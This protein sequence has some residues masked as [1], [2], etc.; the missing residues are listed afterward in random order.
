MKA[1]VVGTGAGGAT[2]AQEL[3]NQGFEVKMVEAGKPFKPLTHKISLLSFLRGSWLIRD[4]S[5]IKRVFPYYKTARSGEDLVI[6]RGV[7]EGGSTTVACGSMVRAETGLKKIG[8]DLTPEYEELEKRLNIRPVPREKWR[9]LSRWMFD[10]AKE[11]GYDPQ[12]TPKAWKNGKCV[13]CGY[14]ELGCRVGAKWDSREFYKDLLDKH[15]SLRTSARV[16]KVILENDR[17]VGVIISNGYSTERIYADIIVLSAGGI[18][19][20]QILKATNLPVRDKLWVDVVLTI[21]GTLKNSNMLQEPPMVWFAKKEHY[22]LSPYFDLLSYWFHNPWKDVS[23]KDLVGMMIKLADVEQ[24]SVDADGTVAKSLTEVD[25][26]H[27]EDAKSKAKEILEASGVNGP[28]V[29][30]MVHGGH[31]GGTVPLSK[32][33]VDSMH[34]HLLPKNLWVADLS[35]A[36]RSQGLPTMLTTSAL[37]LRVARRINSE[38]M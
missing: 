1:I 18:G 14:C 19:T 33:D 23:A 13:G 17:A 4:E 11:L 21:R 36:P 12:P 26:E 10:R 35:L 9:P 28:F 5:S 20:A 22:I 15:I 2:A 25:R 6:F 16:K 24:G 8:L 31:L 32:E 27:L 34:P 38:K 7:A 29:D 3:A 37:A 30:G